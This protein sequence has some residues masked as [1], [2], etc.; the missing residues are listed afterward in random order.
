M[1]QT[2]AFALHAFAFWCAGRAWLPSRAATFDHRTH[3]AVNAF[4]NDR[5]FN[6]SEH[7]ATFA[8]N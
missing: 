1:A 3:C 6:D 2:V 5:S 8:A 7:A 4:D